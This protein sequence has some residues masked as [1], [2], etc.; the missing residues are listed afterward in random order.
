MDRNSKFSSKFCKSPNHQ[1]VS[2][3]FKMSFFQ[4]AQN[5]VIHRPKKQLAPIFKAITKF[6]FENAFVLGLFVLSTR[7][8]SVED[9]GVGLWIVVFVRVDSGVG[10]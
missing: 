7:S 3:S 6:E 10:L 4:N 1:L 2:F 5:K 9:P 8:C